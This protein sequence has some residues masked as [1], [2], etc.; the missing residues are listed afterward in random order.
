LLVAKGKL[1][2]VILLQS[3]QAFGIPAATKASLS[4]IAKLSAA[5]LLDSEK[6]KASLSGLCSLNQGYPLKKRKLC[7]Y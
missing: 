1:A 3:V 7:P 4:C 6:K 2:F 5:A